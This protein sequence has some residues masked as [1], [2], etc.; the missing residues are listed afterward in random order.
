MLVLFG[1]VMVFSASFYVA[2]NSPNTKYD[3]TFMEESGAA[4]G[5]VAMIARVLRLQ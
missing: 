2:E 3:G 1:I 5:L 4:I